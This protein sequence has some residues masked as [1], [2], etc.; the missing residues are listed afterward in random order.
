MSRQGTLGQMREVMNGG[1]LLACVP[2]RQLMPKQ[3]GEMASLQCSERSIN[4]LEL[5][6]RYM[7]EGSIYLAADPVRR[8]FH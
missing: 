5:Y 2:M 3:A 6:A 1:L 4:H 7:R 8:Y